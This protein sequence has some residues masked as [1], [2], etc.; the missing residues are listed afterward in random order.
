MTYPKAYKGVNTLVRAE[1]LDLIAAG[2]AVIL[3]ILSTA[4]LSGIDA[5][6]E[7]S[8]IAAVGVMGAGIGFF[9]VG[10]IILIVGI[11]SEVFMFIGLK[12]ASDDEPRYF[13]TA[14]VFSILYIIMGVLSGLFGSLGVLGLILQTTEKA[15]S[16]TVYTL[17]IFGIRSLAKKLDATEIISLGNITLA[18]EIFQIVV[19]AVSDYIPGI[20]EMIASVLSFVG[21]II[22]LIFL[23]RSR[24]MLASK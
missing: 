22:F 3:N 2:L 24:D 16:I 13:K 20:L 6:H 1:A 12:R 14:F 19:N 21:Y 7:G 23:T 4:A 11:C 9:L 17:T 8:D 5:M 15:V 10:G 18:A